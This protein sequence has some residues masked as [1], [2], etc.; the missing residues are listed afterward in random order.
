MTTQNVAILFTDVVS[1]TE[2]SQQVSPEAGDELRRRHFSILRQALAETGGVEVKNMGDGLMA[3]FDSASAALACGVAMQQGVEV[4]QS[5]RWSRRRPA[6]RLEPGRGQRRGGR[7]LRRSRCGS[8][9]ALCHLRRGPGAGCPRRPTDGR[10]PQSPS[11][12]DPWRAPPERPDRAG[13]DRRGAM[14]TVGSGGF[15]ASVP[16]P[17]RLAVRPTVGLVGREVETQA[18]AD[19]TNASPGTR[20]TRGPVDLRR[21]R[22]RQVSLGGGGGAGRS[23]RRGVRPLRP[24]RREP[25]HPLSTLR[26]SPQPLHHP[27]HRGQSPRA[28]RR[29]WNESGSVGPRSVEEASR[30]ASF[31]SHGRRHRAFLALHGSRRALGSSIGRPACRACIRGSAMGR[32]GKSA[33]VAASDRRRPRDACAHCSRRTETASCRGPTPSSRHLPRCID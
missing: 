25:C 13:R 30:A 31:E 3:V 22:R 12:P 29:A 24:L 10:S 26:R 17:G 8:S 4:D 14:G 1:S 15:E 28:C 32:Q 6:G 11:V 27:H 5:R 7:L 33:A 2:L 20:G 9:P 21:S 18:I 16:L 19:A 23:C